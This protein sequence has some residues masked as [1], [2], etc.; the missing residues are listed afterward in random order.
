MSRAGVALLVVFLIGALSAIGAP[1]AS[2]GTGASITGTVTANGSPLA[3]VCL[4]AIALGSGDNE[5]AVTDVFAATRPQAK[6]GGYSIQL[7][8]LASAISNVDRLLE[9][10]L[11]THN[12]MTATSVNQAVNLADAQAR[13]LG[14]TDCLLTRA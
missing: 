1:V 8:P 6:S 5:A 14:L 4:D 3:N 13:Q 2:A 9:Q 10:A 12:K 11:N 7:D